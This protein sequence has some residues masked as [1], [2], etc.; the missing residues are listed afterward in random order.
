MMTH[1]VPSTGIS[2]I[3]IVLFLLL[4]AVLRVGAVMKRDLFRLGT[5]ER[6]GIRQPMTMGHLTPDDARAMAD[7]SVAYVLAAAFVLGWSVFAPVL[8][9][10]AASRLTRERLQGSP[11]WAPGAYRAIGAGAIAYASF[12]FV[13]QDAHVTT[14][15]LVCVAV[16]AGYR[17]FVELFWI[18]RMKGIDAQA[19]RVRAERAQDAQ[20]VED[21][22]ME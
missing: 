14:I 19:A 15:S 11:H 13:T 10:L 3:A 6:D 4:L 18:P 5:D 22:L 17:L 8:A 9:Y 2:I 7:I 12:A 1:A 16:A 20:G 21:R